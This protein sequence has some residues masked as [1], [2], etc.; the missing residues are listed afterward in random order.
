MALEDGILLPLRIISRAWCPNGGEGGCSTVWE[1]VPP[2][3]MASGPGAPL[4]GEGE[5]VCLA[6]PSS[7]SVA[8]SSELTN[9]ASNLSTVAVLPVCDA[10]PVGAF[11]LELKHAVNAI[12][13]LFLWFLGVKAPAVHAAGNSWWETE[14]ENNSAR[15]QEKRAF[16]H[17][18]KKTRKKRN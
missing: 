5:G 16:S 7:L 18:L 12:G 1:V 9:P 3:L 8:S 17:F 2:M 14:E 4:V 6:G 10:V 13:E 11:T 15:E